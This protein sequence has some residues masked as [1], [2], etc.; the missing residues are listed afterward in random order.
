MFWALR[1]G[2]ALWW[3]YFRKR[4][5]HDDAPPDTPPVPDPLPRHWSSVR[6]FRSSG[7]MDRWRWPNFQPEE[8]TCNCQRFCDGAYWHDPA[9]LDR[10]QAM[11]DALGKPMTINSGHRCSRWNASVNGAPRSQHKTIAA[12][13][14]LHGHQ[15]L[16]IYSAAR[17]AGFTGLGFASTF[18]HVDARERPAVWGYG[19]VG[20]SVWAPVG[21]QFDPTANG[22]RVTS[23][24]GLEGVHHA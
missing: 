7:A 14:S 2:V 24:P 20:V 8:L 22:R 9:F 21:V 19:P 23:I 12:D 18:L 3:S 13:I 11:R 6:E 15:P 17:K 1:T 4:P 10:L 16:A 5:I